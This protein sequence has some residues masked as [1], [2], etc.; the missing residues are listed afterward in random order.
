MSFPEVPSTLCTDSSNMSM[1]CHPPLISCYT[2]Y[3]IV[4]LLNCSADDLLLN[5]TTMCHKHQDELNGYKHLWEKSVRRCTNTSFK[6]QDSYAANSARYHK[7]FS[8]GVHL[9]PVGILG[10]DRM[11]DSDHSVMA[12]HSKFSYSFIDFFIGFLLLTFHLDNSSYKG[13]TI[14]SMARIK[15]KH[16]KWN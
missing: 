7:A 16:V 14:T 3:L 2:V 15:L 5:S 1:W 4:Y 12:N 6:W 13:W 11:L 10:I 9:S 8:N